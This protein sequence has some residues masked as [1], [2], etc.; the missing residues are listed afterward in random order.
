MRSV[1]FAKT[2]SFRVS[3][4]VERELAAAAALAGSS[5]GELARKLVLGGVGRG[6]EAPPARRRI[7]NPE[8]LRAILGELGR[9]GSLLNQIARVL[10]TSGPDRDA[11][12]ALEEMRGAYT[13]AISMMRQALGV[14]RPR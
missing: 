3:A 7:A 6:V 14:P 9:H 8:E 1:Q 12:K 2:I 5:P 10:N 13:E 11:H 4:E